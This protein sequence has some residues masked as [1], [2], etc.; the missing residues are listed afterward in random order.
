[1]TETDAG[2]GFTAGRV[3]EL[4]LTPINKGRTV[5]QVVEVEFDWAILL[6][7]GSRLGFYGTGAWQPRLS[8]RD[9]P[10]QPWVNR[11]GFYDGPLKWRGNVG[12]E[13]QKGSLSADFNVQHFGRY[14]VT[15]ADLSP[16]ELVNIDNPQAVSYQGSEYIPSQVYADV[17]V[18]KRFLVSGRSG[19]ANAIR[20]RF[21]VQNLFDKRPPTVANE[22]DVP[23]STYGD[24]R[25]RR[26]SLAVSAE[27]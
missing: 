19:P 23:Y 5:D 11:A 2:L 21:G 27:L 20:L 13:L 9:G 25:R 22:F 26:F 7:S 10:G 3:T 17:G 15:Y 14:R 4:R 1:L 24:A 6:G 18:S 16:E 8:Q 12:A